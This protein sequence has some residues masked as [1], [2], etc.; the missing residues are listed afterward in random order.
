MT[1]L[2]PFGWR[3]SEDGITWAVDDREQSR[4]AQMRSKRERGWT[5]GEIAAHLNH[6]T[7]ASPQQSMWSAEMVQQVLRQDHELSRT[8]PV[9]AK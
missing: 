5:F 2:R 1:E 7:V 9:I 6:K 4:I 8:K 3:L